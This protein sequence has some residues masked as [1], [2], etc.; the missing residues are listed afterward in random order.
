MKVGC[1]GKIV[2]EVSEKTIQTIQ[3]A[4]WSGS[5]N[6]TE[7]KRH[8]GDAC[9]E[10][11]G[12][13]ADEMEFE[14]HL[15]AWLGVNPLK[16]IRQIWEYERSGTAVPLVIGEKAYGKYRWLIRSHSAKLEKFDKAGNLLSATVSVKLIEYTRR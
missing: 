6:I 10:F 1:L 3:S 11:T 12:R 4:V 14:I 5:V 16:T 8:L 2:F 13:N 15:S 7:H 9:T